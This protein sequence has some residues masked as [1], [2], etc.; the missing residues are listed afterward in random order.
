MGISLTKPKLQILRL[1]SEEPRHGYELS[2]ELG[3]HGSTVYEHLHELED[4]NYIDGEEE[5]RRI[6]YHLTEKGELILE[7]DSMDD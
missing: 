3:L 7:A 2:N 4:E 5:G 6:V 1:L